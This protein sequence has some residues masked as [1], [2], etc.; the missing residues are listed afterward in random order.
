MV[1][2]QAHKPSSQNIIPRV[3]S[4][5]KQ[6]ERRKTDTESDSINFNI[7]INS[8]PLMDSLAW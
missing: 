2:I 5:W 6:K 3:N 4:L 8:T 7:A 1:L